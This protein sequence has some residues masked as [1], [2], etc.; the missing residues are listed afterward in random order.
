MSLVWSLPCDLAGTGDDDG[1]KRNSYTYLQGM[2][3]TQ[4][5]LAAR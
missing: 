5:R 3:S 1:L 4:Q 2:A